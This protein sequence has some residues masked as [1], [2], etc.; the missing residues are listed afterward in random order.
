MSTTPDA[1][2]VRQPEQPIETLL[3]QRW[4]PRAMSGEPLRDAEI[5]TIFEAGR[6]A[7]SSYNAQPWRLLYARR[8]TAHWAT[9]FDL[10]V[11]AN[12]SWCA[13]AAMLVLLVSKVAFDDGRPNRV[14]SFCSGACW[15]NMALQATRMGI[16]SHGMVGFD[17]EG[18]KGKLAIPDDYSVEAMFAFGRPGA[19]EDLPEKLRER[20]TPSQR[21][22]LRETAFE[23]GFPAA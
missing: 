15:Q 14:H 17:A 9:F 22:P 12:Q 8:D 23:G 19:V 13:K 7:P 1:L 6:W 10:L 2:A 5:A 4:S 18:A 16:V 21:R 20:E 11:P 3:V